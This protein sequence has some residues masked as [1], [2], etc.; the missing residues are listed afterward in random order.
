ME[1]FNMIVTNCERELLLDALEHYFKLTGI[2]AYYLIGLLEDGYPALK[3]PREL[4]KADDNYIISSALVN[5][6]K[7]RNRA[8]RLLHK[9][10]P[11]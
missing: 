9:I 5:Y 8:T 10:Y 11:V 7:K 4:R 1:G 6:P 3:N 2:Y